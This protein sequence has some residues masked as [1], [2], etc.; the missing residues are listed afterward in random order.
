MGKKA[1]RPSPK[2]PSS[3]P[4]TASTELAADNCGNGERA[5]PTARQQ[6]FVAEYLIDLN[7]TA[8]YK[9]AGY[10][11]RGKAAESASA[12]MLGNVRVRQAI[13]FAQAKVIAAL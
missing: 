7:A 13:S 2:V 4:G 10:K 5:Q 11:C 9:R 8:A 6:R 3:S 1:K 12:R